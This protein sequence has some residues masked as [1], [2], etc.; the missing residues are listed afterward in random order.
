MVVE[1]ADSSY[2]I[3]KSTLVYEATSFDVCETVSLPAGYYSVS[4]MGGRGGNGGS[5]S[6]GTSSTSFVQIYRLG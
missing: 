1:D 4:I 6:K 5:G 3:G 2:T